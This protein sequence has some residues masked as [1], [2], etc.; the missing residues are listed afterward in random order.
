MGAAPGSSRAVHAAGALVWRE[1]GDRAEV[2]L[3]HRPRY[4]DWSIP[5]GKLDKGETAPAAAVREVAE[6]TGYRVRLQRPLP[7]STY[8]MPDGRTK[9]VQYWA[10][11]VRAKIAPGPQSR[12]EVDEVRW[13][14]LEEAM[15]R[16]TR[17][18]DQVPVEALRRHLEAEELETAPIIIQRHGAALSRKKWRKDEA[19]RPLNSKGKMQA[20]ALPSLLDAFDPAS[21][22]SSPWERCRATVE[23]LATI[24]GLKIRTKEALTEAGHAEHPARTAA[25]IDRV[26]AQA[27][28]TVVCTHRPVLPTVIDSVLAVAA[29]GIALELPHEDPFLAAGEAL[30]LHTTAGGRVV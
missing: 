3:I 24:E 16:V 26:L 10:A 6:E 8:L 25:V 27:R 28:P 17:Q 4:D 22:L 20:R 5:K 19:S 9:V 14:P 30:L 21:V 12:R 15:E 7:T 29:P 23:P 13:V 11:T 18:S 2:L 1:K